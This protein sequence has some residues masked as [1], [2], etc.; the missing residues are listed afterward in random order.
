MKSILSIISAFALML[1]AVCFASPANDNT[2]NTLA[3]NV[4]PDGFLEI[5]G[6]EGAALLVESMVSPS[7]PPVV[8]GTYPNTTM[9]SGQNITVTPYTA[10]TGATSL[11]AFAEEGFTGVLTVNPT[12]GVVTITDALQKGVYGITVTTP[13]G[14]A[15]ATFTL[16]VTK[17]DCAAQYAAGSVSLSGQPK[18][19][20]IGDF[21]GDGIQDLAT[22][23]GN[24]SISLGDGNGGFLPGTYVSVGSSQNVAIGDFNGDGN[25]D[26]AAPYIYGIAIRLGDGSG[27][28][29]SASNVTRL[30]PTQFVYVSIGDFNGDGLQDLAATDIEDHKVFIFQG[31][32]T[33]GFNLTADV[34]VGGRP[35]KI[36]I[37]DFNS[38]GIHD[39]ATIS[40][41][42]D[43][44]SIRLGDG[45]GGFTSASDVSL[46]SGFY[47]S[48]I[49]LADFNGDGIQDFAATI[50]GADRVS[51]RLG[52]GTGGFTSA[53]NVDIG[54]P[55]QVDNPRSIAIGDFNGDG[56]QDLAVPSSNPGTVS[57]RF[58]NG[59]GG[60]TSG[61]D[62][63]VPHYSSGIA[64]G[65]FNGDGKH[66]LAVSNSQSIVSIRLGQSLVYP[67][68][69]VVA[70]Q[71][72][73]VS[74]TT[75]PPGTAGLNAFAGAGFTGILAVNPATGVVKITDALQAGVYEI[76]VLNPLAC[77]N[78]SFTLTVTDP[79]CATAYSQAPDVSVGD[80]PGLVAIGDFNGDGVQD[81][82][83]A[84]INSDNVSIR[85][86]DGA[87]GYTSA[88][89][90]SVGD[91]PR[92]MAIG[93]FNG[94]GKQD[95]A[96]A[97]GYDNNVSVRLGT[98]N[99]AFTSATDVTVGAQPLSIAIG[100]FNG[101]GFQ[102]FATA[103]S[104]DDNVSIRLGDGSG[105]F[106]PSFDVTVGDYPNSIVIGDFDDDGVEDLAVVN[107]NDDDVSIRIG[108]S[109]SGAFT[110]P[111]GSP[112]DVNTGDVPRSITI[113]DF[114]GNGRQDLAIVNVADDNVSIRLGDGLGGFTFYSDVSVG[115]IPQQIA[116]GDFNG[117]GMQDLAIVNRG[118]DNVSI[119]LGSGSG[120][121]T[122]ASNISVGNE[123]L[124]IAIGDF[125]SDG[126]QDLATA[127]LSGDNVSVRLGQDFAY[128][129]TS[130]VAG[131]NTT[132]APLGAPVGVTISNAYADSSF[133]G[134]LTINP[135]TGVVAITNAL[136]AGVYEV[137]ITF[138]SVC[139]TSTSFAL[140]VTDPECTANY[141][142]ASDVSVGDSPRSVVT[143]DFNGDGV[144]DLATVNYLDGNVSIALGNGS[145][146]F[147]AAPD[148]TAGYRARAAA[149]GDFN[150]DGMQDLAIANEV[151]D[152]VSIRLGDGNGAFASVSDV[153]VGNGPYSIAIADFDND[154]LQDFA[155]ANYYDD[156]VSIRLGDG[157][158]GFIS[159]SDMTLGAGLGPFSISNAD[160]DN[161]GNQDLATTSV[162]N[163]YVTIRY[164][165]GS[166]GFFTG[167]SFF[168]GNYPTSMAIGDFNNDGNQDFAVTNY[169]DNE[170]AIRLGDGSGWFSSALSVTAGDGPFSVATG[171]FNGD[172]IQDFAAVNSNDDDVS[173]LI[174]IG[175]GGFVSDS[176]VSVGDGP[177]PIAIGDFNGDGRQDFAVANSND[178][179][180]SIRLGEAA[181]IIGDAQVNVGS[182]IVLTSNSNAVNSWSSSNPGIATVNS[183]G[184]VTGIALGTV[185]ITLATAAGCSTNHSLTVIP[186]APSNDN[187]CNAI[188][189]NVGSNVGNSMTNGPYD[190]TNATVQAGEPL[191]PTGTGGDA[192]CWSQDGWCGVSP[193]PGLDNT[194]WYSLI[195]PASGSITLSTDNSTFDTQVAVYAG[196]CSEILAGNGSFIGANDDNDQSP[197]VPYTSSLSMNCLTPGTTYFVMV[198]GYTGDEGDLMI[199]TTV[200]PNPIV[201]G[202]YP[203]TSV[204]AGQNTT[205]TPSAAPIGAAS[206]NISST[207]GF[208]G[209]LTVNPTTGVATITD[210][211]QIGTYTVTVATSDGCNSTAS[212][213]LTVTNPDCAATYNAAADVSV[214]N[215]PSSIAIGDFN[216]DGNQDLATTHNG[217]PA[218]V[219]IRLGD[220]TGGF[221]SA[222]NV[223]LGTEPQS[224][225]IGDFNGDGMQDFATANSYDDNVSIGLGNGAGGFTSTS[226]VSVG[227]GPYSIAIGDFNGD[228]L[229]DFATANYLSDSV[230][231]RLGNGTGGFTVTPDVLVGDLPQ[232]IVIGDFNGDG[233]QDFAV[234][235]YYNSNVSIRLGDGTGGFTSA[236][237]VSVGIYPKS[238]AIGDFN[239]DG[240]QDLA[241]AN[242]YL[243]NVSIRL[244]NGQGVFTPATDVPVGTDPYSIAIGDFNGDGIQDFATASYTDGDVSLRLGDGTGGFTS[245]SDVSVGNNP[246]S[247]AIGDFNGDGM[248]DFATA[249]SADD[250]F[251]IR[252]GESV[253][254]SGNTEVEVGSSITLNGNGTPAT[255]DPWVSSNTGVA[256]VSA[257]GE[258]TGVGVGSVDITYTTESGCSD[259]FSV[260]VIEM[261]PCSE[262]PAI[263]CSTDLTLETDPGE[264]FATTTLT[265][266]QVSDN[267]NALGNALSFD[268][269]DDFVN[270]GDLSEAN[271]G[272]EDFT[273]EF[274]MKT[275]VTGQ[276]ANPILSKRA[277][278]ACANLWNIVL[279]NDGT[280]YFE[281]ME[282]ACANYVQLLTTETVNDGSWHHV[283]VTRLSNELR[284][285]LDGSLEASTTPFA[286]A[287][288]NNADPVQ[289]GRSACGNYEGQLDEVRI[290]SVA[291]SENEINANMNTPILAQTGLVLLQGLDEGLTQ[292]NN[293]GITTA[294]DASGNGYDGTL[295]NFALTGTASNWVNRTVSLTNNAL[296]TYPI[297][298]TTVTWIAAVDA[299]NTATCDQLVTVCDNLPADWTYSTDDMIAGFSASTSGNPTSWLWDFGE[300]NTSSQENPSHTYTASGTYQV[301]LTATNACG[302]E[303]T[304][305]LVVVANAGCNSPTTYSA[306]DILQGS[307]TLNWNAMPGAVN[308]KLRFREVG[309]GSWDFATIG[310]PDTFKIKTGLNPATDYEWQIKTE[311]AT[312]NSSYGA[313]QT[314]TTTVAYCINPETLSTTDITHN[315]V[316]FNWNAIGNA[317]KYKIR[318]RPVG[319]STWGQANTLAPAIFRTR[320]GLT[321]ETDYEWQ[322]K[323]E[324]DE[325]S[326][327]S[328]TPLQ[329]FTTTADYCPNPNSFTITDLGA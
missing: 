224:I 19:P 306:T 317:I 121:F 305:G 104:L 69:S 185:E 116:I 35:E 160:F 205:V 313:L 13:N 310:A 180:L 201:F 259:V 210:A 126:K 70:G 198:D 219:S 241:V 28:F 85:L 148:V 82:A 15:T 66:D 298:S 5:N 46:G 120:G 188:S 217:G 97:N 63:L 246:W 276:G 179:N 100:D 102:D 128:P 37:G 307:A 197:T 91:Y 171:D 103:N 269:Q 280:L 169:S 199:E 265:P 244:G 291:R 288:L 187:I 250:N 131:Q 6:P 275:S 274:W 143:G 206:L 78:S 107:Q 64:V 77:V 60:F 29:T 50:T 42:K 177:G 302:T 23:N 86:G 186:P 36:V 30:D 62:V 95:F 223:N 117:D 164:G 87:G 142:S 17:P 59:I 304:C 93:D 51:I 286:I 88:S 45:T 101:D 11:N 324:C 83:T 295:N 242:N 268:G 71:N 192:G 24:V 247:I 239:G 316:T 243:D 67:D 16:F 73:T 2:F 92:S 299:N 10:P 141:D 12:T 203:N 99:G 289:I 41:I 293:Q 278:C 145:G 323:V 98:G 273:I 168:I 296:A 283:A 204:I 140:T 253:S 207:A 80:G 137:S 328:Y 325:Q 290:W 113:G 319:S 235:N 8:L 135:T 25:Q 152:D 20:A 215:A 270:L 139:G 240:N 147:I 212:F 167:G 182:S 175:T 94:D 209:L 27:G 53:L 309:A 176:N 115:D 267:C 52:N 49:A 202:S 153:S 38:D 258:V 118:D 163:G 327:T 33:G 132:V 54:D 181:L 178:D 314:F 26:F 57:I 106:T 123:P 257:T 238:V 149:I 279:A 183:S 236:T 75:S 114:N 84:N 161:D 34:G 7:P 3:L 184:V 155:T 266:P 233:M 318:Y 109:G 311:C 55:F 156:N 108:Y 263:N 271:F 321:P 89:D 249:N 146:G 326:P 170:I 166:G 61:S 154:G 322:I 151:D 162:L 214:G 218:D 127:N 190:I 303:S 48:A 111:A 1:P 230:S 213:T 248:Q 284:I 43:F 31:D 4:G 138:P 122:S 32:G 96:T 320:G 119:L 189:L 301:C 245:T 22:S 216:G 129:N 260:T 237:D 47:P 285:Y 297:G 79:D 14:T 282:A 144:Q 76:I 255:V 39:F 220:G 225:A 44:V 191:P 231:I 157:F 234:A 308:Y 150:G 254:I 68:A 287:D 173:I 252:L 194:T 165:N 232:S 221:T 72:T 21:N 294:V 227:D 105:G 208:T 292:G 226:D 193:E 300:G 159:A 315:K 312:E 130:V 56:M 158:G 174:G 18:A 172:G 110:V 124:S 200:N 211:L 281:A 195:A 125:N 261:L 329:Y 81:L 112:P 9:V 40:E 74:P 256:T 58:G 251:S 272:T 133:A 222:S 229:Q 262:P 264:I 65:D 134:I 136:Q 228:G 90:V 196:S 277:V